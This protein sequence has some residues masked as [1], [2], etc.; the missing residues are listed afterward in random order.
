MAAQ[1]F[2]T[3]GRIE[4]GKLY[5]RSRRQMDRSLAGWKDC[6]V[7][8]TIEKAHATRSHAQNAYFHAVVVA[9]VSDRTGYTPNEAKELLKAQCLPHDLAD[10]R[11]GRLV[12]GLVIGGSTSKLNKLEFID[13]LD[14][15]VRWA[16][17]QIDLVIPDPDPRWREHAREEAAA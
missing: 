6:E 1:Q 16:A 11:N 5:L 7:V 10:G 3:T 17:E 2:S 15:C 12:N 9:M 14:A 4:G 8:V 13:F